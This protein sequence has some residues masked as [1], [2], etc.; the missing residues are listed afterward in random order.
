LDVEHITH[1]ISFD[2]PSVPDDY[3]HRIG[4]TAR[5]DAEGDAF[6]LV[7]PAEQG[8]LTAIERHI[9][10]RLPR[11]SLPDFDYSQQGAEGAERPRRRPVE[12]HA[13]GSSRPPAPPRPKGLRAPEP[14]RGA[15]DGQSPKPRRPPRR[16]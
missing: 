13:R 4:R 14:G 10:Q 15:G 7:S 2:V 6:V 16:R 12:K 1:V 8:S 9:G 5:A 11:V 3:V